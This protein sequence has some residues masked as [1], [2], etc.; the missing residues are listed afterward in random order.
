MDGGKDGLASCGESDATRA[1]RWTAY[2][3][4]AA[5]GSRSRAFLKWQSH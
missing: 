4:N 5:V 1:S 3:M 2:V